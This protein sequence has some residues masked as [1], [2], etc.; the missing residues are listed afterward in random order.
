MSVYELLLTARARKDMNRLQ[1]TIFERVSDALLT[2]QDEPRPHGYKKLRGSTNS[3]RIR[4]GEYR[5][6]YD[7]DDKAQ[8]VTVLQVRHRREVY[9]DL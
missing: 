3:Y 1:G 2:L 8:T 7:L 9:R 5:A 6:V 4:V